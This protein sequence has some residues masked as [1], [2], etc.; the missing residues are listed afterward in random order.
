MEGGVRRFPRV[1]YHQ[2]IYGLYYDT[3]GSNTDT[4]LTDYVS[5][6]ENNRPNHAL[7][8]LCLTLYYPHVTMDEMVVAI[9]E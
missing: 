5:N 2:N 9:A 8:G 4:T 3:R 7:G 6:S 1:T